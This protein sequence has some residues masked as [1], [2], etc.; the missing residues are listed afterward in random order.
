MRICIFTIVLVILSAGIVFAQD[1]PVDGKWRMQVIGMQDEFTF[2]INKEIWTFDING[3]KLVQNVT[4]DNKER[5]IRIPFLVT[6]ADYY[7]FE[8]KDKYIE[9]KAGGK[10]NLDLLGTMLEGMKNL[11]GINDVTDDFVEKISKEME[12]AF[13]N[14]PIIRF[15]KS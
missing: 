3:K 7:Y 5:I 6:I 1:F 8:I 9:L 11:Q 12:K 10:F 13:H 4:I 2:E 15:Y 14:V